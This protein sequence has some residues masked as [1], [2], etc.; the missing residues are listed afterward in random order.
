MPL[1][2]K[3]F[4]SDCV[5]ILPVLNNKREK[6][7]HGGGPQLAK[8]VVVEAGIQGYNLQLVAPLDNRHMPSNLLV[9][10]SE[11]SVST[12]TTIQGSE[13]IKIILAHT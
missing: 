12:N 1:H 5:A 7:G 6:V 4:I 11:K 2:I 9:A 8:G 13:L 3:Y 10:N